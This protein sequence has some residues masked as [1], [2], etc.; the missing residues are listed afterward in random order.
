MAG[1]HCPSCNCPDKNYAPNES[2]PDCWEWGKPAWS[3]GYGYITV[4]RR[5]VG[6]HKFVF[7][8]LVGTVPED[9]ELDHTCRNRNC[10]N[11]EHLETVTHRQNIVRGMD[12]VLKARYARK[13][14]V[15]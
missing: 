9:M 6:A 12:A 11:P 4:G 7:E 1:N 5:L 14:S 10:V 15:A 13:E 2:Q 8:A 3:T